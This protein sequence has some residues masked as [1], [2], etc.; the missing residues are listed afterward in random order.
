MS[1]SSSANPVFH[2]LG[3]RLPQAPLTDLGSLKGRSRPTTTSCFQKPKSGGA[4]YESAT[5]SSQ[6]RTAAE[7]QVLQAGAYAGQEAQ[8]ALA[9][10]P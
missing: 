7:F 9:A 1:A 6:S 8:G 3:G 5:L 2:V 10:Q 4:A